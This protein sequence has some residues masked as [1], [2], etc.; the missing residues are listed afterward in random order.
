MNSHSTMHTQSGRQLRAAITAPTVVSFNACEGS[1]DHYV[2][3]GG[4]AGA[5]S[6][7]R[8]PASHE[9]PVP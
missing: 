4:G 9:T 5:Q 2:S 7:D 3:G 8:I 1:K 6:V